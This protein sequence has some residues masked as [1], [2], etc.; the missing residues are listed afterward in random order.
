MKKER[1]AIAFGDSVLKG[2]IMH[3][4]ESGPQYSLS[5]HPF[6]DQC[7]ERLGMEIDNKGR[8]G[9]TVISGESLVDRFIKDVS[10]SQY[11]VL[12]YGGNDCDF[13]WDEIAA[14]PDSV[15]KPKTDILTFGLTYKRIIDKI[16]YA[17]SKPLLLSLPPI[18]SG[19]YFEYFTRKMTSEGKSNVLKWLGGT[20]EPINT[21][22]E[23]YNIQIFKL[24]VILKVP[25]IDITSSFMAQRNYGNCLCEDGIHP[26]DAGQKLIAQS[27]CNYF[28][29][30]K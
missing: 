16:R 20:T 23:M 15:H 6:L 28:A 11:S 19:Q 21:W 3:S 26:N 12:E 17:G 24:G 29:M 18:V 1:K 25:V 7:S 14:S 2:V 5:E 22:H 8:M 10:K 13:V 4:K 27:V 9:S 30:S